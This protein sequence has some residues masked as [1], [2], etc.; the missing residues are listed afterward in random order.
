[1]Y[2]I[3]PLDMRVNIPITTKQN[4]KLS[5]RI[6]FDLIVTVVI[7]VYIISTKPIKQPII[8]IIEAKL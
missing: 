5:P 7:V 8:P 1:M 3:K 4:S 6:N 2:N